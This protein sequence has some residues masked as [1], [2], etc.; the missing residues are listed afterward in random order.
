L[1]QIYLQGKG[2]W[3]ILWR[4]GYMEGVYREGCEEGGMDGLREK[5]MENRREGCVEGGA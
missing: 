2:F 4:E 5:R 1:A 3:R